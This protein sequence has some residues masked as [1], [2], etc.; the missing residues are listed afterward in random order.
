M[1][2]I[3]ALL[4]ALTASSHGV[5]VAAEPSRTHTVAPKGMDFTLVGHAGG[6]VR[7]VAALDRYALVG[8]GSRLLVFDVLESRRPQLVFESQALPGLV[9][10]VVAAGP[11]AYVVAGEAGLFIYDVSTPSQ[12]VLVGSLATPGTALG[13]AVSGSHAY[14]AAQSAGLRIVDTSDITKPVEVGFYDSAGFD[15]LD[16]AGAGPF[17]YVTAG[18]SGLHVLNVS[19]P[20]MPVEVA[21]LALSGTAQAITISSDHA[22]VAAGRSGLRVVDISDPLHPLEVGASR[23]D[24]EDA[25]DVSVTGD[26]AYVADRT[27]WTGETAV[28]GGLRTVD[29]SSPGDPISVSNLVGDVW[30]VAVRNERAYLAS[31]DTLSGYANSFDVVSVEDPAAPSRLAVFA[32]PASMSGSM[33]AS[34]SSLYLHDQGLSRLDLS[35][36][37]RPQLVWNL[38][39]PSDSFYSGQLPG[40]AISGS[41]AYVGA[42]TAGLHVVDL[43]DP[44]RPRL[45]TT[46]NRDAYEVAVQGNLAFVSLLYGGVNLVDIS[47]PTDPTVVSAIIGSWSATDM[48]AVGDYLYIANYAFPAASG[49]LI[50]DIANPMNPVL[51][52]SWNTGL[53]S[54]KHVE[55]RGSYAYLGVGTL[56][57]TLVVLDVSSPASPVFVSDLAF[58][59]YFYDMTRSGDHILVTL[60]FVP[61]GGLRSIDV[62]NPAQPR[63]D[64]QYVMSKAFASSVAVLPGRIVALGSLPRP[65]GAALGLDL[66]RATSP[67]R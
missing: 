21:A 51:V 5:S 7:A 63:V 25:H 31:Y 27:V 16:V 41:N 59:A 24:A 58:P 33:V 42:G 34:G 40:L 10:G 52:G 13:V 9:E 60:P 38:Q 14:V 61:G 48:Q 53:D 17:A 54:P 2:S 22:Y 19:D 43:Q 36:P 35:D 55:V 18:P 65:G 39:L 47:D 4:L 50:Y 29:V 11:Y 57:G 66:L 20:T 23:K 6:Q 67:P 3:I 44:E 45:L 15:I 8:A 32:I 30:A 12:P 37:T 46:L 1:V 28:P 49:L 64:G 62:S 26:Y 56:Q